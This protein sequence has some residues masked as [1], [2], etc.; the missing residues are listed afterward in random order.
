[1]GR[2]LKKK[3]NGII[4]SFLTLNIII[5]LVSLNGYGVLET[6]AN[7]DYNID[8]IELDNSIFESISR[9]NSKII[10]LNKETDY[11]H[12]NITI[13]G[14]DNAK[15]IGSSITSG[16]FNGDFINDLIL[17][18]KSDGPNNNRKNCGAVYVTFGNTIQSPIKYIESNYDMV[19]YGDEAYDKIGSALAVGDINNDKIQDII[20]SS[21][22]AYGYNNG[23]IKSGEIYVLY[24]NKSLPTKWDL[25]KTS[26]NITIFGADSYDEIGHSLTCGDINGD[27][28]DDVIFSSI[29]A[30]GPT[31]TRNSCGETYVIFGNESLPSRINVSTSANITI[32]GI[33][34]GDQSGESIATG[35][36][37]ADRYDDIIIG[38]HWADGINNQRS[39]SG[40]TYIIF[41]NKSSRLNKTIDLSTT[42][43]NITIYGIDYWD[44]SGR[45]VAVGNLNGDKY[46][47][48]IISAKGDG[49]KN[50][51]SDC[52]E[53][54]IIYGNNSMS[55]NISGSK[56]NVIIYG[57]D[58]WDNIGLA[59]NTGNLNNDSIEDLIIGT[60]WGG[61]EGNAYI[62]YGNESLPKTIDMNFPSQQPDIRILGAKFDTGDSV[63]FTDINGDNR[64]EIIIT[65][66]L[67]DGRCNEQTNIGE[68]YIILSG[69]KVL[70]IPIVDAI[71]L[72]N[73]DGDD[74][75][76]CYAEYSDPY[77]FRIKVTTPDKIDDLNSVEL[78]LAYNKP[79]LNLQVSWTKATGQFEEI[80]DPH[81]FISISNLSKYTYNNSIR[82]WTIDFNIIFNRSYPENSY[83]TLQAHVTS[84][85]GYEDWLNFTSD[86]YRVE[87]RFNFIGDLNVT[88][89][90]HGKLSEGDWVRGGEKITWS[91]MKI[92][93][94]DTTNIFPPKEIG[95]FINVSD[96]KGNNWSQ[97]HEPYKKMLINSTALNES[98][99][100]ET[101]SITITGVPW[102]LDKSNL[103]YKLNIDADMVTFS[104]STPDSTNWLSTL[105]PQCAISISDNSTNVNISTIQY[106]I[107]TN[108]GL[109][110][111]DWNS[112]GIQK[113]QN[114]KEVNCFIKPIFKEGRDNLIQWRARDIIGNPINISQSYKILIDISNV[115]FTNPIPSPD[116]WQTRLQVES[117]ITI[118][119]QFSGVNASSIEFST[120]TTGIW[121]YGDWQSA[122]KTIDDNTIQCSVTPTF[123]EGTN[124]YI[125]WRAKDVVGNGY[126][127][128][129]NYQIKI[130]INHPPIAILK[131]PKNGTI[132]NTVTPELIWNG[133]DQDNDT[134]VKYNLFVSHERSKI[135]TL[136]GSALLKPDIN[137]TRYR[138]TTP[139]IDGLTYYWTVIPSDGIVIGTCISGVW[140][141]KVDTTVEIPIVVLIA[142]QNNSNVTTTTPKLYWTLNYSNTEI[143]TFNVYSSRSPIQEDIL[144]KENMIAEDYKLTTYIIESPLTPGETYYWTV[145][146]TAQLPD[147]KLQGRCNSGIWNFIVELPQDKIYK[148]DME[149]ETKLLT[150]A[151]GN[152]TSTNIT[153][154]NN[155]NT[156]DMVEVNFNKG[157]LDANIGIEQSE[158]LI[159]LN[160]SE[161]ITLKI[162]I[163]ISDEAKPENYTIFITASS[164]NLKNVSITRSLIVQ[165]LEKDSIEKED[166]DKDQEKGGE[167]NLML[168]VAI[169]GLLILVIVLFVFVYRSKRIPYVKSELLSKPPKHLALPRGRIGDE[170]EPMLPPVD[171]ESIPALDKGGPGIP[172]EYQLPKAVLTKKQRL[173]ILEERFIL[174]EISEESYKELKI[175]YE[176]KEDITEIDDLDSGEDTGEEFEEISKV[177]DEIEPEIEGEIPEEEM[178]LEE[179]E[180]LDIEE[181]I[182]ADEI[183]KE[184]E[185]VIEE[186]G[187]VTFPLEEEFIEDR[188]EEKKQKLKKKKKITKRKTKTERKP[189]RAAMSGFQSIPEKTYPFPVDGLCMTCGESLDP[190]MAYC[191]SCGTKYEVGKSEKWKKK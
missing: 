185:G 142:P 150:V 182:I 76:T 50:D 87:N 25:N 11:L 65:A 159:S 121:D 79:S 62:F 172:T 113:Y 27:D 171:E 139:L 15:T 110:W 48:I 26:P 101:Y 120:S 114:Q 187:L 51:K 42:D 179:L 183:E 109:N 103:K 186:P 154:T 127:I 10:D 57:K 145:I 91:G 122:L 153:I 5:L 93:Y 123:A 96:S 90:Y 6:F 21:T 31:N 170:Q 126:H 30:D 99:I 177:L 117:G 38:A 116:E 180:G 105:N 168:W 147:G 146:P 136:N 181:P 158:K 18:S 59:L 24:G 29:Y 77:N 166:G 72:K 161:S 140:H 134:E 85:L 188:P 89:E 163:L 12:H 47:D 22:E 20:I 60:S 33:D 141:F 104:K 17:S 97:K 66:P 129:E 14:G 70:P 95:L 148:L 55:S 149:I 49:T 28:F 167:S 40:E 157:T 84:N 111:S 67:A 86:I 82:S 1:M 152:Y 137:Y 56:S 81:N 174:G 131:S 190:D 23:K 83:H 71:T 135:I 155:G 165:V 16:D 102:Y 37:N 138:F 107:S 108:N 3:V 39:F 64:N 34:S 124:N 2:N 52:G 130:K 4:K 13:Y 143:I 92:V 43:A 132:I 169:C 191:W 35:D 80:S 115:T 176:K 74:E 19:V 125:R 61:N 160:S 53:V 54:Y 7:S 75:K 46:D 162:E 44:Y 36:I 189:D 58:V 69:G 144:K 68:I 94:E 41:G 9:S 119:D 106:R 156:I 151:Q 184:L 128:S 73:G 8:D 173:D 112:A 45:I 63:L 133:S 32:Y 178:A 88:S 98:S 118:D 164:N 78:G 175:K 100:N